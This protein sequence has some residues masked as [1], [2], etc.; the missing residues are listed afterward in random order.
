MIAYRFSEA[1][2]IF[3]IRADDEAKGRKQPW[4]TR[5]R[6]LTTELKKKPRKKIASQWSDIKNVY[7]RRQNG[8]CA[9]CERLLGKHELSSVEFD[10]EHFRP[11]NAVRLWPTA[12]LIRDL[13]LPADFPRPLGNGKGYRFL[14]YH[15]LN[16]ASSCKTCNS[17]LKGSYF[18]VAGKHRFT[19]TDPRKLQEQERPYLIYPLGDF[20]EDPETLLGFEGYF[21]IPK[22]PSTQRFEHDRARVTI[23]FFRLNGERDDLLLL[24]AKQL[25]NVFS[26]IELLNATRNAKKKVEIWQDIQQLGSEKNDHASCVRSLIAQYGKFDDKPAPATRARALANLQLAREYVRSQLG[27]PRP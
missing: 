20:D 26:K 15:H 18:P 2:L 21:A 16:Y 10:V 14:A 11:K 1:E 17:R 13:H 25:D 7:T 24:R 19:G 3:N 23:A 27:P 9:F 22:A 4:L 12:E 5:A 6:T 8:K